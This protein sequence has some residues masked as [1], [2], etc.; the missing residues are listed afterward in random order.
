ML[1]HL[2]DFT[3][4]DQNETKS[5]SAAHL[6]LLRVLSIIRIAGDVYFIS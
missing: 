6:F 1:L 5:T 3:N 2:S 4:A